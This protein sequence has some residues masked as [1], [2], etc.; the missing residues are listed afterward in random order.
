MFKV[1]SSLF[2]PKCP[3][4]RK[5]IGREDDVCESC[6]VKFDR[7]VGRRCPKCGCDKKHC[8]CRDTNRWYS[9]VVS[10]FYLN[11]A[12]ETA[13]IRLKR[14]GDR[15]AVGFLADAMRYTVIAE[16]KTVVYDFVTAVPIY[17]AKRRQKGFAHAGLL[18]QKI[19]KDM[20]LPCFENALLQTKPSLPQHD[21][22]M[23]ERE[24]N[25]LD[26]Y[27]GKDSIVD[28]KTV[29]LVDDITTTG[30]TLDA[31]ARALRVAGA[32]NVYCVTAAKTF[33]SK[34]KPKKGNKTMN[35]FL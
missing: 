13:I 32:K 22:T 8:V 29:L 20:G 28:G 30:A 6:A 12:A 31:C 14:K 10:P 7:I 17:P 25:V 33:Y 2:P 11:E 35:F 16:Y 26:I 9:R 18:A 21:L 3:V 1:I 19:A 34:N 27:Q 5:L 23:R 24:N 15:Q 4:C